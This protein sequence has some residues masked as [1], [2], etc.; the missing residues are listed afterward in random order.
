MRKRGCAIQIIPQVG[1]GEAIARG[2]L[3]SACEVIVRVKIARGGLKLRN[4]DGNCETEEEEEE[5]GAEGH[6]KDKG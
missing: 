1:F 3:N 2:K 5:V 6:G 4:D